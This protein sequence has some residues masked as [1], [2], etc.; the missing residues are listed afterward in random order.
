MSWW[1]RIFRRRHLYNDLSEEV[2]E[3]IEKKTGQLMRL[4]NLSRSE[5]R[6]V[7]GGNGQG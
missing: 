3:H 1:E 7:Q 6:L 5:C 2:R 4:Q